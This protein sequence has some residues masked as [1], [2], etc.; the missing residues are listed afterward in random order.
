MPKG[1][2]LSEKEGMEPYLRELARI[3]ALSDEEKRTIFAQ[4]RAG[5]SEARERV[6]LAHLNLV[7]RTACQYAGYGLPLADLISEGNLALLRAAELFDPKHGV[8]F[9]TYAS[10]WIKQRIHRA[11]TAQARVVRIPV[12]RSQRLRKLGRLQDAL[13]AELGRE[14]SSAELAE[15]LGLAEDRLTRMAAEQVQV[16]ELDETLR[17]DAFLEPGD[18]LSREELMEEIAACLSGLD[19]TELRIISLK[20]GLLD[21]ES[22]SFREMAP[23]F[24]KSREW[25]RRVGEGALAKLRAS[26]ETIGTLPRSRIRRQKQETARRLRQLQAGKL[27]LLH[28]ALIYGL[29][30]LIFTL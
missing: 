11:I 5:N 25:I 19:D 22:Q 14:A 26:F 17:D 9:S 20:F 18:R 6:V 10:V 27:S 21:E 13:S 16:T 3:P 7:V 12:W 24:G 29:E 23:R 4:T 2:L 8:E 28:H 30:P 1:P 15:K